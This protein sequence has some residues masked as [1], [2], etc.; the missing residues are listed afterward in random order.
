VWMLACQLNTNKSVC[1]KTYLGNL[2]WQLDAR[3]ALQMLIQQ[4]KE[5]HT[6]I[7]ADFQDAWS[8]KQN[9]WMERHKVTCLTQNYQK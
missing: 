4:Q 1:Y 5:T 9:M 8:L 3:K 7:C 2:K 6:E